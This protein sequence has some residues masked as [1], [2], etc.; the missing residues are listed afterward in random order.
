MKAIEIAGPGH[1]APLTETLADFVAGFT[2][3]A[4][5][6]A[7]ARADR[8]GGEGWRCLPARGRQPRLLD[9]PADRGLRAGPGRHARGERGRPRLSDRGGAWRR[10]PTAPWATPAISSRIT[11]RRSC[12]PIAIM[13][14]TALA[15]GERIGADGAAPAR[16]GRARLRGR[17]PGLDGARARCSNTTSASI[18]R[19]SRAASA[20][21]RRRRSCSASSA[22]RSM[23]ALGLAACQASG[24]MAWESDPSENARPFQMGM[25]A[26]NGVTAALLARC[27]FRRTGC[28]LRSR[29]HGVSA[30]SAAGRDRS[31]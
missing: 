5:P 24:L 14:P 22:R 1:T 2:P 20:R 29:P 13:L 16:R 18:P 28:G 7:G 21:P 17:V 26:R 12:I 11:P 25:A 6:A 31:F 27:R 15:V 23:R 4:L 3:A 10:S 30:R 8:H 19:R 9:R